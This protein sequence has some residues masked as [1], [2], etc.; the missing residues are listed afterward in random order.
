MTVLLTI[1]KKYK[2]VERIQRQNTHRIVM[3]LQRSRGEN[4]WIRLQFQERSTTKGFNVTKDQQQNN[5]SD[6]NKF[7]EEFRSR[8]SNTQHPQLRLQSVTLLS[9]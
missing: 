1:L 8:F 6:E 2:R 7:S 9:T 4:D 3:E 5:W